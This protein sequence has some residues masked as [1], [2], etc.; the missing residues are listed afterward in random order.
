MEQKHEFSWPYLGISSCSGFDLLCG[1]MGD[2]SLLIS[3]E[4][5]VLAL[6]ADGR[7]Y[8]D[9]LSQLK[10]VVNI[11]GEGHIIQKQ[12]I[13]CRKAFSQKEAENFLQ[14]SYWS[15]FRNREYIEHHCY[16]ILTCRAPRN[17]FFSFDQKR[18]DKFIDRAGKALDMLRS[19]G[20]TLS[21]LDQAAIERYIGKVAAMDFSRERPS[22][23]NYRV[24]ADQVEIGELAVKNITLVDT[25][26]MEM[27]SALGAYQRKTDGKAFREFAVDNLSFLSLIPASTTTLYNQIIEVPF[28]SSTIS[29]LS[30]KRKRHSG[31]SDAENRMSVQDIDA[32]MEEVARESRLIVL[33]HF[34]ICIAGAKQNLAQATA[35]I[36]SSLFSL[37][38]V[39]SKNAYNQMELFR[40]VLPGNAVG[41]KP[42]D[43][44]LLSCEAALCLFFKERLSV[45]EQSEFLIYFTD[46]Q[47]IPIGIDLSDE[48]MRSGRISNR[49]KFVLGGSGSGKSFFMNAVIEQYLRYNMDVVIIDTGH[50]YSGICSYYQGSYISYSEQNPI[51]MNPFDFSRQE[52]NIEKRD[53]LKTLICL[54]FKGS[55]EKVSQIEDSVIS[56]VISSFYEH[57]FSESEQLSLSFDVFYHYSIIEI[58]K[59]IEKR[60]IHFDLHTYSY[61]LSKFTSGKE[62]GELLNKKMDESLFSQRLIC[63][64]ID[65]VADHKVLFPI[66]T[67][68]IMDVFLQKMR[69]RN[70]QRKALILEEAWVRREAA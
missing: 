1:E 19:S 46:R 13:F 68:V 69:L 41:L 26:R 54:L 64:E 53:F 58:Q 57:A 27:P 63:F 9:F 47:G 8:D 21:V 24:N 14:Q 61:V 51:T 66:L 31:I 44:F 6:S 23:E 12:D 38:I 35:F 37:G 15:H 7:G 33:A 49:S 4:N 10:A 56:E 70:T 48:P 30:L 55:G 40:T 18:L 5:P 17:S 2:F 67:L 16:M 50:S 65:A 34:N 59:L 25:D 62:Y 3:I 43:C 45:S 52:Y 29:K 22:A 60:K 11:L 36:E 32:L 42:Y 28:Q 20:I 39:P